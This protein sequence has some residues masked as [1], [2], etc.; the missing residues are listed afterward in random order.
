MDEFLVTVDTVARSIEVDG[1]PC[2]GDTL[3]LSSG[4]ILQFSEAVPA[5]ELELIY[6]ENISDN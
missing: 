6:R 5:G 4:V 3:G 1:E 2:T